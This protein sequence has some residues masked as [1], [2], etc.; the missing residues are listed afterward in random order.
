MESKKT[1]STNLCHGTSRGGGSSTRR[2]TAGLHVPRG[3]YVLVD[4]GSEEVAHL[5]AVGVQVLDDCPGATSAD[6]RLHVLDQS[7]L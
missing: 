2:S 7:F 1:W 5:R 4:E 6:T 3:E